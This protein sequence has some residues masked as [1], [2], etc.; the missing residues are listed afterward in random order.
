MPLMLADYL[1]Q[2]DDIGIDSPQI[3]AQLMHHH[4]PLEMGKTF[5][6]IISGDMQLIEACDEQQG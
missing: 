1:L 3:I 6:N 2:K 4:A 5:V